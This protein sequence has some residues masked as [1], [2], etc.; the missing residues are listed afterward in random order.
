MSDAPVTWQ[1]WHPMSNP[2]DIKTLGKLGEELGE[3]S[4][5]VSRCLIQGIEEREPVSGVLNKNWLEDELA[6]VWVNMQ[7]VIERFGLDVERMHQRA[8]R[9]EAQLRGWHEEA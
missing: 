5:A 4:A 8:G 1:P 9:K 3:A 6:D 7:L 2:R